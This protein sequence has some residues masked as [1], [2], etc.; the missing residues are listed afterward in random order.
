MSQTEILLKRVVISITGRVQGVGFRPFIYRLA[1][2]HDLVG[3]ICNTCSG[4][5][6]DVQGDQNSLLQ[7]QQE[8]SRQRPDGAT[9]M[10]MEV[11]E[12]SL[13]DAKTF[14]IKESDP[15]SEKAMALLPD[16]ALCRTCFEELFDPNNRRYFY[17]FLHCIC[18]GPRF[19]LFLQMPFDRKNTTMREFFMCGACKDEYDDTSDR[20]FYSQTNCCPECGPQLRLIDSYGNWVAD[21]DEV[22][23][24]AGNELRK[25]KI[26]ALK[27]TGGFLL[28]ADAG[29]EEAVALLRQRKKRPGKPFALLMPNLASVEAIA[30]LGGE[31]KELLTSAAAPIVLL[32]K[33]DD[34]GDIA[35]SVAKG[36]PNFGVMLPHNAL[37][38]ILMHYFNKP[39]VATSGNLSGMPLCIDEEEALKTLSSV[40][41]LFLIHNRKI[42]H[43]LDDSIVQVMA[44]RP[45]AIR[46]ARGYIPCAIEMPEQWQKKENSPLFATGS[47]MK[48]SFAFL[49]NGLIYMGQHIG[50]LDTVDSCS[51]Y[52]SEVAA[53][54]ELLGITNMEGVGDK[55]PGYYGSDYL[56]WREIHTRNVQHHKA[57][58]FSG[59][60]DNKL[61]FPFLAITWDGTGWGDDGTVWGGEAFSASKEA[62]CRVATLYPF[63]LQ[64]GE[65]A[66]QE[67]R[68]SLLGML[69][70]ISGSPSV[71]FQHQWIKELFTHEELSISLVA[72]EREI[73]AP[74]CSSMGRLFDGISA[75]LGLCKV[76][77]FEGQA[78]MLLENAAYSARRI[79]FSYKIPL[80]MKNDVYIL[81]WR[82]MVEQMIHELEQ[83]ILVADMAM[84]YHEA[85]AKAILELA[86]MVGHENVLLTGGVMQNRLLVEM[87]VERLLGCGFQVHLHRDIPPNDGGIAAGQL[88]GALYTERLS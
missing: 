25:G 76:S 70:A 61:A 20:R 58:A 22:V 31:E 72:L 78:A 10:E 23:E 44:G 57:H 35:S 34:C 49:K 3:T 64:G 12:V 29:N 71:V 69:Y 1:N 27:N 80:L 5:Q 60:L 2:Q 36:S 9:I 81:D 55:H 32:K 75:L 17:P 46:K 40:A 86:Q 65:R 33:K 42:V 87:T 24:R 4:V 52:E 84:A 85:L 7:F 53:W 13:S 63:R 62:M 73:N 56:K 68:R 8:I 16:T 30:H 54:E 41:D 47:Q 50:D 28:L 67:P 14:E 59:M 79:K 82:P 77:E 6:I 43:R 39:L 74:L 51:A 48:N 11:A 26:V 38:H 19:S 21:R 66:V 18:C 83:G 88:I 37:Q 45:V 15:D